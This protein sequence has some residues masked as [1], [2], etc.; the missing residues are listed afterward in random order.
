VATIETTRL[1][2]RR[3]TVEDVDELV[4]I[5][6]EPAVRRFMGPFDRPE[7]LRWME[8]NQRDWD[9]HGYGRLAI[10]EPPGGRL[11]GRTGLKYWPQFGETEVGWVLRPDAWGRGLAT[12]A[13][14]ACLDWG[15]RNLELSYITAMIRPDNARSIGV[16]ARLG[17]RPLREDVLMEEGVTVYS[18]SRT[19]WA[20]QPT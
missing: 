14:A 20:R 13:A 17:M 4:A 15:F 5:H 12:E 19:S 8:R 6:A 1:L 7:A 9:E 11:L 2:L 16:A 10:V 18:V 3:P